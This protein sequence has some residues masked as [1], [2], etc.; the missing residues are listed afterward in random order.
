M[1]ATNSENAQTLKLKIQM[2]QVMTVLSWCTKG[3]GWW[4]GKP[5]RGWSL[6]SDTVMRFWGLGSA[7]YGCAGLL[8]V[9][10]TLRLAFALDC[11]HA[12]LAPCRRTAALLTLLSLL[13]FALIIR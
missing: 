6:R 9:L 8:A 13:G 5:G 11:T 3:L 10:G 7:H 2:P 12:S 4:K 1:E